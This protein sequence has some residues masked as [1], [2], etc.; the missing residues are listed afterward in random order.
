MPKITNDD[1]VCA[2]ETLN[3][4]ELLLLGIDEKPVYVS[5]RLKKLDRLV[6]GKRTPDSPAQEHF[7]SACQHRCTPTTPY[8]RAYIKYKTALVQRLNENFLGKKTDPS[9]GD[10]IT[11]SK[12]HYHNHCWN[13]KAD[14][15]SHHELGHGVCRWLICSKCGACGCG[16]EGR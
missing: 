15:D 3:D 12:A 8:E 2:L 11:I 14:V 10:Y 6:S 1:K 7:M 16:Y 5:W 9:D 13:C 4:D